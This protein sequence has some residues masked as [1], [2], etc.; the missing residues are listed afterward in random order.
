V[1][2]S[3]ATTP[4]TGTSSNQLCQC[5]FCR[6]VEIIFGRKSMPELDL[7]NGIVKEGYIPEDWK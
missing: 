6:N 3:Y 1:K 2:S 5:I 4:V 7:C